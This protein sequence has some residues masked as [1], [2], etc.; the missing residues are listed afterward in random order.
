MLLFCL[1]KRTYAK[2]TTI[3]EKPS[4]NPNFKFFTTFYKSSFVEKVLNIKKIR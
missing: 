3:S 1:A 2:F 4:K